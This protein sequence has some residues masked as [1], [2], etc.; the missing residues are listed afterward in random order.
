MQAW[1]WQPHR[2]STL[3]HLPCRE[4]QSGRNHGGLQVSNRGSCV[5]PQQ[6][7]SS[8][9]LCCQRPLLQHFTAHCP[10]AAAELPSTALRST[11]L[12]LP[13]FPTTCA[14]PVRLVTQASQGRGQSRSV[15]LF[16]RPARWDRSPWQ[17][18]SPPSSVSACLGTGV[19]ENP[20]TL[21]HPALLAPG[22]EGTTHSPVCPVALG[23]QVQRLPPA[24]RSATPSTHAL[25]GR[26]TPTTSMAVCRCQSS[27]VCA[28]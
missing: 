11:P 2:R 9:C 17:E 21:A 8:S 5:H 3:P 20:G 13:P 15:S 18:P 1:V 7:S 27:S 19:A 4:L 23:T 14:G 28:R 25:L 16:P 24:L 22:R 10:A 26:S 6:S 12:P